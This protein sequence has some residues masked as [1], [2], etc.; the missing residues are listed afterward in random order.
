[1]ASQIAHIIYAQ[2]FF[3]RVEKDGLLFGVSEAEKKDE[4]IYKLDKDQFLLGSIFPDIRRIDENLE[5]GDTH[6]AFPPLDL[7]FRGLLP[8][9]AGWKFHLFCDMKR[10][11]TIKRKEFSPLGEYDLIYDQA[12][13]M[14]EDELLYA[15]Y[16]N[17]EKL[18]L[19]FSNAPEIKTNLKLSPGSFRFWY[20]IVARY[21]SEKPNEKTI[22]IF[23][24]KQNFYGR[25]T[26]RADK[27]IAALRE[28]KKDKKAV[29]AL[30]KIKNEIL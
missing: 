8:F 19:F 7:D 23:L 18:A 15:E 10:L 13:K 1:M 22:H 20:S 24:T 4:K 26:K 12:G 16:N 6:L 14:L 5:R 28:I 3:R 29:E 9:E 2:E 21:F 17:W 11:E 30:G 27:I 25:E